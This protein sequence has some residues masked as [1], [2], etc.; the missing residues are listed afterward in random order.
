MRG[1]E[2]RVGRIPR[3]EFQAII[4]LQFLA[5]NSFAIDECAVL[6]AL[7]DQEEK[8]VF[9]QH[10]ERVIALHSRIRDN[11][12][13]IYLA[14]HTERSAVENNI[15]LLVSLHQHQRRKHSRPRRLRTPYRI[16]N[17]EM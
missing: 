14:S 6:A 2:N 11:Q 13:F 10:N 17:H 8:S 3:S 12:I 4:P 5:L 1:I 15:F 7:I 16:K 9:L